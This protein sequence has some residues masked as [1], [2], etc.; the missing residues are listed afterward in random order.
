MYIFI[1]LA[2]VALLIFLD[3]YFDLDYYLAVLGTI[4]VVFISLIVLAVTYADTHGELREINGR[5]V[6]C[7]PVQE[8]YSTKWLVP[9]GGPIMRDTA[10]QTCRE[11][12]DE[13]A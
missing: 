13:G 7:E 11:I 9:W 2:V 12:S 5:D 6:Y 3:Y 10:A 8:L 4:I 1:C